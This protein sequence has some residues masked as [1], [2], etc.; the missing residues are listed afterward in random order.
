MPSDRAEPGRSPLWV[1]PECGARL[2]SRNLWH[3][4][5]SSTLDALF[6]GAADPV[7]G[8]ARRYV[9]VLR[10]LRDVQ[11][12]AQKSRLVC[13]APAS[14]SPACIPGR[15][16]SWRRADYGPRWR[17][18]FVRIRSSVDVDDELRAW[19]QESHDTVGVQAG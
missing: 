10:E 9:A 8:A 7:R 11:V 5:V 6:E 18:H 3:S 16:R 19:L 15:G 4:R 2:V 12:I 17:G 13:V 14:G 1:C